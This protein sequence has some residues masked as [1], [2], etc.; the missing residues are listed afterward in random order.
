MLIE[1]VFH[2]FPFLLFYF[3]FL[4]FHPQSVDGLAAASG[5][6]VLFVDPF[7]GQ[8]QKIE[9]LPERS[10]VLAWIATLTYERHKPVSRARAASNN[11]S[12]GR[13]LARP[14]L[15]PAFLP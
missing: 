1:L 15:P 7:D 9:T 13:V 6:S 3:I 14:R 4:F 2:W 8:P 11:I 5:M 10:I 12:K